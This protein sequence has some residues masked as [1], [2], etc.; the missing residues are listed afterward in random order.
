VKEEDH[1]PGFLLGEIGR[2]EYLVTVGD[3]RESNS[4]IEEAGLS[5]GKGGH[6]GCEN[7]EQEQS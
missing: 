5:P 7:Q 4:A 2:D 1:R 6:R 3:A